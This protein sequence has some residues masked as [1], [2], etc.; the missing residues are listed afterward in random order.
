MLGVCRDVLE[1]LTEDASRLQCLVY[2]TILSP[3][4]AIFQILSCILQK[5]LNGVR[6]HLPSW[7]SWFS[8]QFFRL[9]ATLD[10]DLITVPAA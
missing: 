8:Q 10:L 5:H 9:I 6:H 4:T 1:Q 3:E 7:A 2:M